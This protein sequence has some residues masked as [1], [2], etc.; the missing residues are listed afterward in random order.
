MR[1]GKELVIANRDLRFINSNKNQCSE[2]I[3]THLALKIEVT[4]IERGWNGSHDAV[5]LQ[6]GRW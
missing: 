3:V 4:N 6:N 2:Q 5:I 1:F